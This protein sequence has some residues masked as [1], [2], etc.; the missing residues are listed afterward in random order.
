MKNES[1]IS[2]TNLP[3]SMLT[4]YNTCSEATP[5]SLNEKTTLNS[6]YHFP[7]VTDGLMEKPVQ[8]P[9]NLLPIKLFTMPAKI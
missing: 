8:N 1:D 6:L 3:K 7:R 4:F 2:L 5:S 9:R